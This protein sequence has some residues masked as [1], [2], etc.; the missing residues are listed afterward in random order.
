[1]TRASVTND[2]PTLQSKGWQPFRCHQCRSFTT[3]SS[4]PSIVSH[5]FKLISLQ[6]QPL[7]TIYT[8]PLISIQTR[9]LISIQTRP[10]ISLQNRPRKSMHPRPLIYIHTSLFT[11]MQNLTYLSLLTFSHTHN[12]TRQ[13]TSIQFCS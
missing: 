12:Y 1:M 6:T 3:I 8:R 7:I 9:P 5:S 10:L 4:L 2:Y 11:S 13:L